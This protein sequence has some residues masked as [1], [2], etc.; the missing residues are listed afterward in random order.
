MGSINPS[1]SSFSHRKGK[2]EGEGEEKRAGEGEGGGE[3]KYSFTLFFSKQLQRNFIKEHRGF[4][5][6]KK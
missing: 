3:G 4:Y 1:A 5:F 2:E 6:L